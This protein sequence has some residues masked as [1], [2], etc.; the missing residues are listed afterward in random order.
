MAG[1]SE[2]E[3]RLRA[4]DAELA[5]WAQRAGHDLRSPL[6]VISGMAETLEAAWDRLGPED[7]ARML[8]AIKNQAARALAMVD[9]AVALARG[10]DPPGADTDP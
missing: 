4:R 8:A 6:A 2:D 3:A 10:G 5:A 9:E 7:R 1:P